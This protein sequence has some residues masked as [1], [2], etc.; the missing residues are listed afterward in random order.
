MLCG[1][2]L[3]QAAK[4]R[5]HAGSSVSLSRY[6]HSAASSAFLISMS[7][8]GFGIALRVAVSSWADPQPYVRNSP[9]FRVEDIDTPLLIMHGDLD[10]SITTLPGAERM[11]NALVRA[12]KHRCSCGTG[13]EGHT[14]ESEAAVRDQWARITTWF[15]HYLRGQQPGE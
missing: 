9:I 2:C 7:L 3:S 14:A 15:D 8:R 5:W 4:A 1:D 6:N 11:Y 10:D 13:E 12:G